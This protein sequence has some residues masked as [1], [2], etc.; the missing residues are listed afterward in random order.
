MR[1]VD[2][3][4]VNFLRDSF[5]VRDRNTEGLQHELELVELSGELVLRV[6]IGGVGADMAVECV[7]TQAQAEE[8]AR[9]AQ[10]LTARLAF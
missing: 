2:M 8:F 3:G 6:W 9:G 1:G 10:D 4:G 5:R 7:L